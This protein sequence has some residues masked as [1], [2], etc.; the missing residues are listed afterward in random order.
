MRERILRSWN[1][2]QAPAQPTFPGKAF[3]TPSPRNMPCRDSGLPAWYTEYYGNF[4]KR[5]WTTT[6]S[7]RTNLHNLWQFKEFGISFSKNGTWCWRKH[8]ETG[9][10]NETRTTKFVFSGTTLPNRSCSVRSYWW[11]LFSQRCGQFSEISGFGIAS[12]KISW[13]YGISKLESQHQDWS[14]FQRQQIFSSQCNGSKKLRQQNQMT[15]LRHRNR[16]QGEEIS[17]IMI[18]LMLWL[19]LRRRDFSTSIFASETEWV[20]KSSVAQKYDQFLR[21]RQI[22]YMIYGHFRATGAYELVQYTF[23]EWWCP[24]FRHSMG[25][26]ST[27]SKWYAFS[28]DPGRIVQVKIT[29][30]CSA[31]GPSWLCTIKKPF[32]NNGQTSYLRLKTSVK[33]HIDQM[34]RT[35]NFRVRNEVVER[36][37]TTKSQNG[38]KACVERKMGVF[39][40]EGTWTMFK[41][42]LM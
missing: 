38:Q 31:S 7:R 5:F 14:M 33:L 2:E 17:M 41:R 11:N 22:A 8:K 29:G 10:W 24:R 15:I 23:T 13:L 12:G 21:G 6:C 19:R 34:M 27:I 1:S 20:S 36:G 32:E 16:L 37:W 39:S 28:C 40:V 30:L 9:N 26:S 25:S 18:C 42:R 3:T 35:P 4:R